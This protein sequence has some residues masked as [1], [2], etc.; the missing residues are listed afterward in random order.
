MAFTITWNAA[1][2][3]APADSQDL[4][5]G[6]T[7]IREGRKAVRER[8]EVDHVFSDV[9][10]TDADSGEHKKIT[11]TAPIAAPGS[12]AASKGIVYIKDVSSKA[13]LHWMDEDENE[14]QLTTAGALLSPY[15]YVGEIR[16][17]STGSPPTNWLD[18]DGSAVSR[19]TYA[20]LFAVVGTTF[21]VGDGSTTFNLPD[22]KGRSPVGVGQGAETSEGDT[23][24]TAR[25]LA[26]K[27]GYEEHTLI[28]AEMAAHLHTYDRGNAG[29]G[30]SGGGTVLGNASDIQN[31]SSVGGDTAHNNMSPGL[32]IHFIIYA[33]E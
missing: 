5:L 20:L 33:G 22:F 16:M 18:C 30:A 7:R 1:Y 2:E 23:L 24:G 11:F 9:N 17:W 21:G 10:D 8:L 12:V 19:T 13:E 3:A 14:I 4:D 15:V 29:P 6:A 27:M 32:A 26:D 28:T 25:T 31:T